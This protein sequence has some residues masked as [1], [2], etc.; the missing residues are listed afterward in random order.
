MTDE[1][2]SPILT[3]RLRLRPIQ[4][5]DGQAVWEAKQESWNEFSKWWVWTHKAK[6]E[7]TIE[8]DEAFCRT[9]HDAYVQRKGLNH[10]AFDRANGKLIGHGSLNHCNW[11]NRTFLIGYWVRSSET[12]K[13]Y[14]GE[15]ALALAHYAFKALNARKLTSYHAA[16][17]APSQAV[18]LKT[19]FIHE[20]TLRQQHRLSHG[21]VDELHYGLLKSDP[22]PELAVSW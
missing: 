11:E 13:G 3:P 8:D 5:G 20:G 19:G 2:P 22:L 18:L 21:Y 12:G 1:L 4:P 14:A 16:G 10:L 6:G 7:T 15:I 9:K 17:N